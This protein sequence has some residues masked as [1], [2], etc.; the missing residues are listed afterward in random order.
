MT[1]YV[2]EVLANQAII[3]QRPIQL[4]DL[5]SD[6]LQFSYDSMEHQAATI[7]ANSTQVSSKNL[8]QCKS[9]YR[10]DTSEIRLSAK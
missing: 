4:H 1:H 6:V 9:S 5:P 3:T 2:G 10:E 8:G 7:M